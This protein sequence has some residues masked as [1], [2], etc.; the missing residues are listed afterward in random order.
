MRSTL[1]GIRQKYKASG[2]QSADDPYAEWRKFAGNSGDL[3]IYLIAVIPLGSID[4]LGR[5]LPDVAQ[6]DTGGKRQHFPFL[7]YLF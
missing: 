5:A 2:N 3:F 7:S 6:R 1:I 4:D